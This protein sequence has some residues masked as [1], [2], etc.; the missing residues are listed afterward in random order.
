MKILI[1]TDIHYGEDTNH[2]RAGSAEYINS[3]GSHVDAFVPKINALAEEYDLVI[4]LG[5]LIHDINADQDLV[6]YKKAV[7]LFGKKTPIKHVLGNHDTHYLSREQLV[8]VM[9][10]SKPYYSFD[11]GG[12]HHVVLDSFRESVNENSKIDPVQT[13]WL[14][15]DL[16]KTNLST[17]VYCHFPLD[18]Q[19]VEDNYYFKGK[20]ERAFIENKEEIRSLLEASSKVLTVFSGHLHFFHQEEINGIT[21]ITIP[22]FT[23]ND[24]NHAPKAEYLDVTLEDKQVSVEVKKIRN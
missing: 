18:N 11:L 22:A 23:E 3:F 14:Q 9:G 24:G 12:Y 17:I 10:E 20:P 2:P 6:E 4:N 15:E 19:S 1:F 8:E 21:Y 16:N 13:H 5:D 7:Q